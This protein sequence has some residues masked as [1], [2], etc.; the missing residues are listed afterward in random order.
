M[1][2]GHNVQ[3]GTQHVRLDFP[4]VAPGVVRTA[5]VAVSVPAV[6]HAASDLCGLVLAGEPPA[7]LDP[8]PVLLDAP[9]VGTAFQ[10]FGVPANRDAGFWIEAVCRGLTGG[11]LIQVQVASGSPIGIV[12]GYSGGPLWAADQRAVFG[13]VLTAE[14]GL[15]W[16]TGYALPTAEI[17]RLWPDLAAACR[18]PSPYRGLSAFDEAD[19]ATFF[20]RD[21]EAERLARKV[22]ASPA[23]LV[24]SGPGLGKSSLVRAAVLPRLRESGHQVAYLDTGTPGRTAVEQAADALAPLTGQP[25]A[26]A[27]E[28][29]TAAATVAELIGQGQLSQLIGELAG[30][31][32]VVLVADQLEELLAR[33]PRAVAQLFELLLPHAATRVDGGYRLRLLGCLRI[34]Y[35]P[36]A[37]AHLPVAAVEEPYNLAPLSAAGLAE[38][39]RR[40][41]ELSGYI[42]FTPETV[43][44]IVDD[45][46]RSTGGTPGDLLPAIEF[47][48][49]ELWQRST[50]STVTVEE[51]HRLGGV[52]GALVRV[53]NEA[54]DRLEPDL[55]TVTPR[56]LTRLVRVGAEP[57][58]DTRVTVLSDELPAGYWAV[59][60]RL[61]SARLVTVTERPDGRLGV[62]LAHD[63]LLTQWDRLRGW[64]AG[65]RAFRFWQADLDAARRRWQGGQEPGALLRG[66][67]LETAVRWSRERPDDLSGPEREFIAA[68]VAEAANERARRIRQRVLVGGF[69][70]LLAIVTG[71]AAVLVPLARS[72][73]TDTLVARSRALGAADEASRLLVDAAAQRLASRPDTTR[74]MLDDLLTEAGV[75]AMLP[76]PETMTGVAAA[77]DGS[78]ILVRDGGNRVSVWDVAGRSPRLTRTEQGVSALATSGDGRRVAM[79]DLAGRITVRDAGTWAVLGLYQAPPST[80][81]ESAAV[82]ALALDTTGVRL[83]AVSG[84]SRRVRRWDLAA[85]TTQELVIAPDDPFAFEHL[86]FTDEGGLIAGSLFDDAAAYLW[87]PAAAQA[88]RMVPD[89]T[90]RPDDSE[91]IAYGPRSALLSCRSG[92][93]TVL[94]PQ[95]RAA[96]P[97]LASPGQSCFG[98][99]TTSPP[100]V[101][102]AGDRIVYRADGNAADGVVRMLTVY[103]R[104]QLAAALPPRHLTGGQAG[105]LDGHYS[106]TAGGRYLVD[107][108]GSAIRVI[109]L[110]GQPLL[111][112]NGIERAAFLGDDSLLALRIDGLLQRVDPGGALAG[113]RQTGLTGPVACAVTADGSAAVVVGRDGDGNGYS[114]HR[115]TLPDLEP[116]GVAVPIRAT[117]GTADPPLAVTALSDGRLVV[118][119]DNTLLVY[120]RQPESAAPRTMT[121]SAG[122][123][124][125]ALRVLAARPH[126]SEVA[127]VAPSGSGFQLIDVDRM[128][129][130]PAWGPFAGGDTHNVLFDRTGRAVLIA[131]ATAVTVDPVTGRLDDPRGTPVPDE[132]SW[133]ISGTAESVT[134]WAGVLAGWGLPPDTPKLWPDATTPAADQGYQQIALSGD[135]R[136]FAVFGS[137]QL[138]VFPTDPA[139]W[140]AGT[141]RRIAATHDT[142]RG[143][144][145]PLPWLIDPC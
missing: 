98:W 88:R 117:P 107:A 42:R 136:R 92:T 52:S 120:P 1:T 43:E 80:S 132:S 27:V 62:R 24:V 57:I 19:H 95:T 49:T 113:S 106:L 23:T 137:G 125:A 20:G 116:L 140:R 3:A 102:V 67:V 75:V 104:G 50:G 90:L 126:T 33:D 123:N 10:L 82:K 144:L 134:G 118:R 5:E 16:T 30:D 38:A 40:P 129:A 96:I 105:R 135:G 39:I 86:G 128:S 12:R 46:D 94:D 112:I 14:E 15:A 83:A 122:A 115:Y 76:E 142:A 36:A 84:S 63:A 121:L 11:R 124:D 18:P 60:Q 133:S 56:L 66:G 114:L 141:C 26:T 31:G 13:I 138:A 77:G 99:L 101:A 45:A 37:T 89:P 74:A 111:S 72:R 25:G 97:G 54:V 110:P 32:P 73:L 64:I 68:S 65:D 100:A 130:G 51:Y 2:A 55:A 41:A 108:A 145:D 44:R 58:Q 79:A 47:T 85:G 71:V 17:F 119:M 9:A 70:A 6:P 109:R 93:I 48:A 53:A 103:D 143:H 4:L 139:D 29:V 78:R 22:R 21:A 81:S 59:A 8:A 34:D 7:G 91:L 87:E 127:V 35:L 69:V 61:A 28:R 131:T